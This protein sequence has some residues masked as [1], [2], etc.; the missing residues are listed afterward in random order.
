MEIFDQ[1]MQALFVWFP[2]LGGVG[3]FAWKAFEIEKK[4]TAEYANTMLQLRLT[5][6]DFRHWMLRSLRTEDRK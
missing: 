5:C 6:T 3:Y 4:R 2:L 1:I